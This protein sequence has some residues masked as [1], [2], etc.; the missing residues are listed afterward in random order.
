MSQLLTKNP[1]SK[2]WAVEGESSK[3]FLKMSCLNTEGDRGVTKEL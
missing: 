3:V 1:V 2:N